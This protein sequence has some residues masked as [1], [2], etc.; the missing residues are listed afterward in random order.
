MALTV[1]HEE[2]TEPDVV[3]DEI[4]SIAKADCLLHRFPDQEKHHYVT[5]EQSKALGWVHRFANL[6]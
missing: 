4:H 1:I 2:E 3:E 6:T 5:D